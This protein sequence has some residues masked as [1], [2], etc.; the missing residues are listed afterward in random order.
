MLLTCR[1]NQLKWRYVLADSWFSSS[2]NMK[3]IHKNL[4]KVFILALKSNRLVALTKED[5]LQ[6]RYM[7]ID[8]LDWS[9][10]PML[11]WVKGL[12]FPVIFHRQNFQARLLC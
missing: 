8:S 6:G 7:R 2:E 9:E 3:F 11:G 12:E 5:K 1:K 4:K 10:K